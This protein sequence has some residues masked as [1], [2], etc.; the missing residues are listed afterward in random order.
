[1][2]NTTGTSRAEVVKAVAAGLRARFE[3]AR[4]N[5]TEVEDI[6]DALTP[7]GA[8]IAAR[9]IARHAKH[10]DHHGRP[11]CFRLVEIAQSMAP[12]MHGNWRRP[13]DTPEE[14][15]RSE[16]IREWAEGLSDEDC[17]RLAREAVARR[18]CPAK[19]VDGRD[20]R[21]SPLGCA[22]LCSAAHWSKPELLPLSLREDVDTRGMGRKT[23]PRAKARGERRTA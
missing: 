20:L 17:R 5:E 14:V 1:V 19:F 16:R 8:D 4:L 13:V 23:E 12:T 7:Y 9:A 6:V 3:A 2:T 21:E 15:E 18:I 22:I 11:K 10:D